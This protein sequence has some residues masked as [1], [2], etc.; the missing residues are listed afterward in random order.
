MW[1]QGECWNGS[2]NVILDFKISD[3]IKWRQGKSPPIPCPAPAV[4]WL[5][6]RRV[7]EIISLWTLART[8]RGFLSMEEGNLWQAQLF[9][10]MGK[11]LGITDNWDRAERGHLQ[12]LT[13]R[14]HTRQKTKNIQ[15]GA[16]IKVCKRQN[17]LH[18]STA[19][20]LLATD[21]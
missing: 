7:R 6:P 19:E 14:S 3:R 5:Q 17:R 8:W 21:H 18:G 13:Q 4:N 16:V 9:T 1:R 12:T 15:E 20:Q 11:L 2:K 10:V